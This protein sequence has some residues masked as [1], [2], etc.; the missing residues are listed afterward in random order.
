MS[1][2]DILKLVDAKKSEILSR[3]F[4]GD[5]RYEYCNEWYKKYGYVKSKD[6]ENL[7]IWE[8]LDYVFPIVINSKDIESCKNI[9]GLFKVFLETLTSDDIDLFM[10]KCREIV[11]SGELEKLILLLNYE[12]TEYA[13]EVASSIK[14][15]DQEL[16]KRISQLDGYVEGVGGDF[17]IILE[18][19]K[20]HEKAFFNILSVV[21]IYKEIHELR[22]GK[23]VTSTG[24]NVTKVKDRNRVMEKY[25]KQSYNME[26]I[27][28]FVNQIGSFVG[29]YETDEKKF[30]RSI[31]KEIEALDE[32]YKLL[33]M[34]L[35]KV[36][37]INASDIVRNINDID[38][39]IAILKLIQEHNEKGYVALYKEYEEL[40]CNTV[41][42]YRAVLH[43][44]GI[45]TKGYN[46]ENIMHNSV[47]DI[48]KILEIIIRRYGYDS[49]N[50]LKVLEISNLERVETISYY[51]SKG[52]ISID[53]LNNNIDLYD[54]N[55]NKIS[56]LE[57]NLEIL[58]TYNVNPYIF[59]N[60]IEV[61]FDNKDKLDNNLLI[62][63]DYDLLK[64]LKTTSNYSFLLLDNLNIIIDRIIELGFEEYLKED[65]GLLNNSNLKRLEIIHTLNIPIES[66]DE[67]YSLLNDK[68][69]IIDDN[70]IDSY[71]FDVLKYKEKV[72]FDISSDI[73]DDYSISKRC[74]SFDGVLVSSIKVKKLIDSG[75]DISDA[76]FSNMTLSDLEYD[77]VLNCLKQYT[78]I[79]DNN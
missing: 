44:F 54:I 49:T 13:E 5:S 63:R 62:L 27:L 42:N 31:R 21:S 35:S 55:S 8:T 39:R 48:K 33:C 60:S 43:D 79:K 25:K 28:S 18:V 68:K 29:K 72:K 73:L 24:E 4:D 1:K 46:I 69:F 45:S 66:K 30:N 57:K 71:L 15:L 10:G 78:Y 75:L 34:S 17:S 59:K 22:N 6:F 19:L 58:S 74:Y 76:I 52:N 3:T 64:Y 23:M 65:I 26:F 56:L 51:I 7:D 37:V 9:S 36:E 41:V 11:D 77:R 38:I 50:A 20:N 61:L 40:S 2:E 12:G 16:V 67:L 70:E 14:N 47:E 53:Y 32:A